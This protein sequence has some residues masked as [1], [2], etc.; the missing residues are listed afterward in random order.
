[1]LIIHTHTYTIIFIAIV[2]ANELS[3]TPVKNWKILL[4][5]CFPTQMPFV[6]ATSAFRLGRSSQWCY[7]HYLHA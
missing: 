1:M 6:M 2:Q 3:D 7:L 5:Q 4:A